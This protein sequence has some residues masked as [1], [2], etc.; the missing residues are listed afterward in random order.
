MVA[1]SLLWPGRVSVSVTVPAH[2]P[3]AVAQIVLVS[4]RVR[5]EAVVA[6][7]S[8]LAEK[9]PPVVWMLKGIAAVPSELVTLRTAGLLENRGTEVEDSPFT[10]RV[11]DCA[12]PAIKPAPMAKSAIFLI[13]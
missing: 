6:L 9:K 8:A 13:G 1:V 10:R 4:F 2:P 12:R 7:L 3:G 5:F 11:C